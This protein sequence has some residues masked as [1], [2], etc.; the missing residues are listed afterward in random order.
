M[1]QFQFVSYGWHLSE[2]S[3]ACAPNSVVKVPHPTSHPVWQGATTIHFPS[4]QQK[5]SFMEVGTWV[6]SYS[7]WRQELTCRN[8][9]IPLLHAS[10][11]SLS[12]Q[13]G[14]GEIFGG[15]WVISKVS[16]VYTGDLLHLLSLGVMPDALPASN[17]VWGGGCVP[18]AF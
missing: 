17:T 15:R 2:T 14:E 18:K 5:C 3:R 13:A 6:R 1:P 9:W 10:D 4:S 12:K 16:F 11:H 8:S 7:G